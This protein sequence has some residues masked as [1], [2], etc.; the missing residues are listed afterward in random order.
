MIATL[1]GKL[2]Y[3]EENVIVIECC[4]VGYK[5]TVTKNVLNN[6]PPVNEEAFIHTYM[7]VREDAMELYGFADLDELKAFK[8]LISVNG[9]GAKMGIALLSEFTS[10]QVMY[11]IANEDAKSLTATNGVG[12]KLAQRIVLELKDK[13]SNIKVDQGGYALGTP[14]TLNNNSKEAIEGLVALGYSK[15]EANSAV[16]KLDS[17]LSVGELIKEALKTLSRRI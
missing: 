6:I 11:F 5:C 16:S 15:T 14:V 10:S 4:G 3:I 17:S 7:V 12:I 1:K 13:I 2:L 9:V 8:L